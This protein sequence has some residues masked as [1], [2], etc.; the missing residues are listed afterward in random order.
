MLSKSKKSTHILYASYNVLFQY[1]LYNGSYICEC[2]YVIY[3]YDIF[4]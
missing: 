1:K 3:L 4:M 2:I